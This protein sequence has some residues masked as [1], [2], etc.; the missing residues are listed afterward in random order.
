[1]DGL[2]GPRMIDFLKRIYIEE[3]KKQCEFALTAI[4]YFN[5]AIQKVL[6]DT[7]Q[8]E[9]QF[10][11][12]EVFRQIHSF[13]THT[14][15]VSRMFWPMIPKRKRD[16]TNENYTQRL[17]AMDQVVRAE[18]LKNEYGINDQNCLKDRRLRDH[19]EHY[20]ERLDHWRKNSTNHNIINNNIG[21]V[22]SIAGID[23]SDMMRW[24]DPSRKMFK[25][26]GEEFNLECLAKAINELHVRSVQIENNLWNRQV[27]RSQ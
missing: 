1:M 6:S 23:E 10:F 4:E 22:G 5:L 18:F 15:N 26:R 27:D 2:S 17:A 8:E 9:R 11:H 3:I 19:L 12:S 21:P 25:F 16:E 13:L 14:S 7:I 20:D 24:Y